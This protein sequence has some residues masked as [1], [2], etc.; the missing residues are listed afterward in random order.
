MTFSDCDEVV[1]YNP[2]EPAAAAHRPEPSTETSTSKR[3]R[4]KRIPEELSPLE[5]IEKHTK[6]AAKA[7]HDELEALYTKVIEHYRNRDFD[8]QP[9][10]VNRLRERL[11]K[12]AEKMVELKMWPPRMRSWSGRTNAA[13]RR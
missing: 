6:S 13:R 11:S 2:A 12:R 1:E 3:D 4:P 10:V 8:L 7:C 9:S 5:H